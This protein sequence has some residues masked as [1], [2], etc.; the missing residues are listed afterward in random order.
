MT[1]DDHIRKEVITRVMCDMEVRKKDIE[2]QFGIVFDEYFA[3]SYPKLG[4]FVDDGLVTLHQ[5]RILVNGMGRLVIRNIAMCFDAY[6]DRMI[7]EKP[8]FSKTV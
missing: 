3:S 2:S 4:T 1:A 5:D 8:I 6:L 7:K